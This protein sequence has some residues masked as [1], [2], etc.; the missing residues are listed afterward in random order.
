MLPISRA[1]CRNLGQ[2]RSHSSRE[3][4]RITLASVAFKKA[5]QLLGHTPK[6]CDSGMDEAALAD[7]F[8]YCSQESNRRA[9][10]TRMYEGPSTDPFPIATTTT[11]CFRPALGAFTR[12]AAAPR[13]ALIEALVCRFMTVRAPPSSR[14]R[15][16]ARQ[17]ATRHRSSQRRRDSG[18]RRPSSVAFQR[19]S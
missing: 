6:Q 16:D 8:E 18:G 3:A 9:A 15:A 19:R 12:G 5:K 2:Q 7:A 10:G 13:R 14:R 17:T 11:G 1:A 4:S